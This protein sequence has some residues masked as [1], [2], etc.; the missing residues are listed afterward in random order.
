MSGSSLGRSGPFVRDD[1][2]QVIAG[3]VQPDPAVAI[4]E[5]SVPLGEWLYAVEILGAD[6]SAVVLLVVGL[7]GVADDFQVRDFAF[8][9]TLKSGRERSP[10]G[11]TGV[12]V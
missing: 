4:G 12:E 6:W 7:V 3:E 11:H 9:L 8:V 10:L 2:F 5:A 1:F